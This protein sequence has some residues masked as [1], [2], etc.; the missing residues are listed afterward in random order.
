MTDI[1]YSY[2]VDSVDTDTRTMVVTYTSTGRDTITTSMR[3]P[4]NDDSETVEDVVRAFSPVYLWVEKAKTDVVVSVGA[5]GTLTV[6]TITLLTP[7]EAEA[8]ADES[9][10][11][12]GGSTAA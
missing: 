10:S 1:T 7:A 5:S 8:L 9:P 11:V 4:Y 3:L 12:D 2:I 6:D